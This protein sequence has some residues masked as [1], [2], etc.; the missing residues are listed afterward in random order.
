[1]LIFQNKFIQIISETVNAAEW[2]GYSKTFVGVKNLKF[3]QKDLKFSK[4]C[5]FTIYL[6]KQE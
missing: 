6:M 2:H 5:D 1:M 3:C 4:V